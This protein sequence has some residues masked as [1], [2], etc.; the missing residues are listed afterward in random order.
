MSNVLCQIHGTKRLL[1]YP[2]EDV[3]HLQIA[4]GQSSSSFNMFDPTTYKKHKLSKLHPHVVD[5]AP[6]DILYIPALWLHTAQPKS[7]TSVAVNVFFRDL[8]SGYAAGRDV[9][10]NRDV[11]AYE[12]GRRD[13]KRIAGRFARLPP[14]MRTFY[15][16]QLS[17]ELEDLA[18]K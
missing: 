5:L 1:L 15:L 13:V 2:P 3:R 11:Q 18:E 4:P 14:E 16:S 12:D 8:D 9:Y 7:G 10:G 17:R 6:G